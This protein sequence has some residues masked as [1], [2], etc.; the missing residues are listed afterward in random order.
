M[1]LYYFIFVWIGFIAIVSQQIKV[2]KGTTICG[3]R[4]ERWKLIWA[5]IAFAPV[6]YIAAFTAPRSDTGLYLTIYKNLDISWVALKETLQAD[7][8]GK[9]FFVFQWIIKNIF[10]GSETAFRLILALLHSIPV[11]FLFRKYSDKFITSVYLF[12]ATGCHLA[13]MMNGLRQYL[14]VCIIVAGTPL[15]LKRK[16]VPL[17]AL[18]LLAATIHSSAI[19]MLPVVFIIQGKAWNHKTIFFIIVAIIMMYAFSRY[20]GLL[21]AMLEETEYSGIMESAAEM[22]DDGTNPIRVLVN[23]IPMLLSLLGKK[24]IDA[25]NNR[26]INLC[27]NMSIITTGLYLVSMV[28]SG[29]MIGRLPIYTSLYSFVALP[30]F[31]DK[32]FT[33]QSARIV[34]V[35]MIGLYFLYYL[36]AYRNF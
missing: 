2:T 19:L 6:M 20:S 25:E 9:G 22:G 21:D 10:R 5:V 16:Y 18:I 31:V 14:A 36:Y 8:S 24:Q 12:L 32:I 30:Y 4:V 1:N 17:I 35:L 3:E 28:T 34:N 27:V 11:L 23:S 29:I 13:W 26:V 7:D 15:M 33:K